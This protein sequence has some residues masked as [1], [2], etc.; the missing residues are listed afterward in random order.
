MSLCEN[1]VCMNTEGSYICQCQPPYFNVDNSNECLC[2]ASFVL[3]LYL[4]FMAAFLSH[5]H[6]VGVGPKINCTTFKGSC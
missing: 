1:A 2:E 6:A 4:Y 3:S 5:T